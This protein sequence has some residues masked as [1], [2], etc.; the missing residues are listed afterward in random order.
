M[1]RGGDSRGTLTISFSDIGFKVLKISTHLE[2][3]GIFNYYH[4]DF[5]LKK[6]IRFTGLCDIKILLKHFVPLIH[7]CSL[8]F[9]V[10]I[11]PWHL[12]LKGNLG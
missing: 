12:F 1:A 11:S 9:T 7:S 3:K 4:M 2:F 5:Y 6:K 8:S 10:P